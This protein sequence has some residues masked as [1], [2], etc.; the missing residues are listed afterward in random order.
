MKKQIVSISVMS[1]LILGPAMAAE[2][3][4]LDKHAL[5]KANGSAFLSI[6]KETQL[7]SIKSV[8]L[9]SG[10]IKAKF[11]QVYNSLPVWGYTSVA[12]K[13]AQGYT[14]WQGFV[15]KKIGQDLAT[16]K[17]QLSSQQALAA[18]KKAYPKVQHQEQ[19]NEQA[20]LFVMMNK[21]RKAQLVYLTSFVTGGEKPSRPTGFVDA[22]T[23][24]VLSHWEGLTT[25]DARGPG[26]NEKTGKY[27]YGTDFPKM[28][29]TNDCRMSTQNVD[30]INLN[31]Q[32]SG[33][34]IYQF[35]ECADDAENTFKEI[36][37]AYSPINDAHYFGNIVFQ[38]YSDW[39]DAA[40]LSF[41][42]K[43]RVHYWQNYENAFWDGQQMTFGD[44]ANRFYPLV[45]L[46]VASHEVSHG[47]TEQNSGLI[48]R[49]QSGGMNESF[50]DI[51]GEA[52]EFYNNQAHGGGNDWM[53]G[54][55]IFK[56]PSGQALRYF[57]E[58][59]K[60]GRSIGHASKYYEGMGV[61]YS[62]GVFNRAFYLLAHKPGWDTHKAFDVFV[63]ANQ[64]YWASDSSFDQGGCGVK[65][66][67]RDLGYKTADVSEAFETVGVNAA[68]ADDPTPP[69]DVEIDFG[70]VLDD[71]SG[72]EGSK[73][74]YKV[75]VPE[76]INYMRIMT[77]KG[78]GDVDLYVRYGERATLKKF[79]C[80]P[81]K[82][83][84]REECAYFTPKAGTYYMM[85]HG[86]KAYEGVRFFAKGYRAPLKKRVNQ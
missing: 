23:G 49:N 9:S 75:T 46:D 63:L 58:P 22:N 79:D 59:E 70:T 76:H 14:H 2:K 45:S 25:K 82:D 71:L 66:A 5:L 74:Y 1:A 72:A 20:K 18:L 48:Y 78:S 17:P 67:A 64:L 61:H 44:G 29:V 50:S 3:M 33:G 8:K 68:C 42:L 11:Q 24:K 86:Y 12:D 37:G 34:E 35:E 57:E 51:A 27:V 4:P 65:S 47:F 41:K 26:G 80:R 31:H 40:P 53:V 13:T 38:M 77:Y 73:T 30:T 7:K 83:G 39:Y 55:Q 15:L 84:N 21:K 52:A 54:E 43:M 60:D 32:T 28:E 81:Y 69:E 85:L 56:G 10:K 19:Y 6:S 36:N 62:S 16:T